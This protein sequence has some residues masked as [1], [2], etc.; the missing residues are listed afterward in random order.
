MIRLDF[1]QISKIKGANTMQGEITG[2][3]HKGCHDIN[4]KFI[5]LVPKAGKY[6][7]LEFSFDVKITGY[8]LGGK[9]RHSLTWCTR[10]KR[11]RFLFAKIM[12]TDLGKEQVVTVRQGL[13]QV[14]GDKEKAIRKCQMPPGEYQVLYVYDM[15]AKVWTLH[16]ADKASRKN[17]LVMTGKPNVRGVSFDGKQGITMD[18]GHTTNGTLHENEV[19]V[20][21]WEWSNLKVSV[22]Q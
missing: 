2:A 22:N 8:K 9:R 20:P 19:C 4:P 21:G 14:H 11:H 16:I 10:D 1:T 3:F 5:P 17:V 18:F 12:V 6:G 15:A 13:G 7:A